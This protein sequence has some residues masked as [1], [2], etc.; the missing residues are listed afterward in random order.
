M[1]STT[2][3]QEK[4]K[5]SSTNP[6]LMLFELTI[7]TGTIR[8]VSNT[9]AITYQS[10]VYSPFPM[11]IQPPGQD[12]AGTIPQLNVVVSNVDRQIQGLIEP[13]NGAV[14][15]DV[16][17]KIVNAGYLSEDYSEFESNFKILGT[18]ANNDSVTFNLGLKSPTFRRFPLFR[19]MGF[20]CNWVFKGVECGYN[21]SGAI[22]SCDHTLKT[23]RTII[24]TGTKGA[25]RFGGFP[26]LQTMGVKFV[27]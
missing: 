19:M 2:I 22:A 5:L 4:N 23:C 13:V 20:H 17:I 12:M 11:Q 8:L 10:N 25:V 9:E 21:P 15:C 18:A 24:G 3:K 27:S 6:W 14:D 26:G 1:P 16:V 7:G